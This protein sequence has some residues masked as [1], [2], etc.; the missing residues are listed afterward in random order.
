VS[1][2]VD[3]PRWCRNA[4]CD[5]CDRHAAPA[6]ASVPQTNDHEMVWKSSES[7]ANR[8]LPVCNHTSVISVGEPDLVSQTEIRSSVRIGMADIRTV[9][10]FEFYETR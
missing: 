1:R 5:W 6:Q 2:V 4:L 7:L 8:P 10:T 3:P 9:V